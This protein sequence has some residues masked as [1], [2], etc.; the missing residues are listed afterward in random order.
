ML[1]LPIF[2]FDDSGVAPP[3]FPTNIADQAADA[4]FLNRTAF[5]LYGVT[6]F[7][8]QV[9]GETTILG[10]DHVTSVKTEPLLDGT[11]AG[12]RYIIS[13]AFLTPLTPG[14]HTVAIGGIVNG[15]P[16]AFVSYKV[17][18]SH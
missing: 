18:V 13:A 7:I 17:T 1:Y 2:Y 15:T 9:D 11:P 12:T 6:A 16:V 4:A 8:V 14:E 10:D 3:G 5:E